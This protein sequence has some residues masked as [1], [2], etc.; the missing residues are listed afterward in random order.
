MHGD[1]ESDFELSQLA[2]DALEEGAD[3]LAARL[4][5]AKP[6]IERHVECGEILRQRCR[7]ERGL[8]AQ[9]ND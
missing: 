8:T 4:S 9:R 5:A 7:I 1:R 2:H 6:G 3:D